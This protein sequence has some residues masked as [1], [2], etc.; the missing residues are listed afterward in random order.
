MLFKVISLYFVKNVSLLCYNQSVQIS[1][2]IP[3]S[4]LWSSGISTSID[5]LGEEDIVT[6]GRQSGT[7][8][9]YFLI[10]WIYFLHVLL[11]VH[12]TQYSQKI[13]FKWFQ[14]LLQ[15]GRLWFHGRLQPVLGGSNKSLISK[16]YLHNLLSCTISFISKIHYF[17]S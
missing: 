7:L 2:P 15:R 17:L 1:Q 6:L 12:S 9:P 3:V 11:T 10:Y 13:L 8:D 4:S 14:T 16:R 5:R